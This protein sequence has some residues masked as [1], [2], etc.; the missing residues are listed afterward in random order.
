MESTQQV[1]SR[2]RPGFSAMLCGVS[3][4]GK[5][6]CVRTISDCIIPGT[7]DALEPFVI[8]TDRHSLAMIQQDPRCHYI[9]IPPMA[10][11]WAVL[12]ESMKLINNLTYEGL[13]S[14]KTGIKKEK[15]T[16]LIQCV[17]ALNSFQ[18]EHCGRNFGDV[19]TW[20]TDRVLVID[21]LTGISE[22]S[23][24]LTVGLRP[25]MHEGEWG[26]AMQNIFNFL[27][28][29]IRNCT[30]HFTLMAHIEMEKDEVSGLIYQMASTLGKKLAPKLPS[31]FS[32]VIRADKNGTQFY[33]TTIFNHMAVKGS[34]LPTAQ[35]IKPSFKELFNGWL[36]LGGQ[37]VRTS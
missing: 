8:V 37:V 12:K 28:P 4:T 15:C 33:W 25:T 6:F 7:S 35:T 36:A 5:S 30:C 3:G 14:L 31:E 16:Q 19:S 34:N 10:G 23:R 32:D 29:V 18:C 9:Y 13:S 21:H 2:P 24:Q 22:M 26:V 27:T 1:V 17:D 11:D 20:G